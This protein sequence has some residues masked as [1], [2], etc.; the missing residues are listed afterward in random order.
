MVHNIDCDA[1]NMT[2]KK[3]INPGTHYAN[4]D[5]HPIAETNHIQRKLLIVPYASLSAAQKLDI[6]FPDIEKGS[7][8]VILAIRG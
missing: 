2:N 4:Q 5:L 7:F 1:I 6:Y 8:P 3:L